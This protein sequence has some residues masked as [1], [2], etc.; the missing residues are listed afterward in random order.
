MRSDL[1]ILRI[2]NVFKDLEMLVVDISTSHFDTVKVKIVSMPAFAGN[3]LAIRLAKENPHTY[4]DRFDITHTE[5]YELLSNLTKSLQP[6]KNLNTNFNKTKLHLEKEVKQVDLAA[7][8]VV[9]DLA[10]SDYVLSFNMHIYSEQFNMRVSSDVWFDSIF[11]DNFRMS[12][13]RSILSNSHDTHTVSNPDFFTVKKSELNVKWDY[14]SSEK[15]ARIDKISNV[16]ANG[17]RFK[18]QVNLNGT[19]KS[20]AIALS[21]AL[22]VV[23]L[24]DCYLH[25]KVGYGSIR[26]FIRPTSYQMEFSDERVNREVEISTSEEAIEEFGFTSNKYIATEAVADKLN[27]ILELS[28]YSGI[29]IITT[30]LYDTIVFINPTA[31]NE[32]LLL[33][34]AVHAVFKITDMVNNLPAVKL[35]NKTLTKEYEYK[36]LR[37]LIKM[38]EPLA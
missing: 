4:H 20:T 30:I 1:I 35:A 33:S 34:N 19:I 2:F 27:H 12:L 29:H 7:K 31:F 9:E 24:K 5:V 3:S 38:K 18:C 13:Q 10:I 6:N 25:Y 32:T 26:S 21:T 15:H 22:S 37:M 8:V 36:L 23:T 17:L 11:K 14:A 28:L 16:G